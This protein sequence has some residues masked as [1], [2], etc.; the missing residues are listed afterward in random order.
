MEIKNTDSEI[1]KNKS[2][3]KNV[4]FKKIDGINVGIYKD[5]LGKN[6]IV[7]TNCPH[8]GCTLIFNSIEKTWD[9]PCHASRFDID[10]NVISGPSN[11]DISFK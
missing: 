10:G 3:Y 2:W 5:E 8:L 4:T 6:H 1:N 9:C 7:K 11:Y